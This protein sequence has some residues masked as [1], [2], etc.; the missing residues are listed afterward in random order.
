MIDRSSGLS[1]RNVSMRPGRSTQTQAERLLRGFA[2]C[3]DQA[4]SIHSHSDLP[5]FGN[6]YRG[7]RTVLN[8]RQTR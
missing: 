8:H 3:N 6:D 2:W 4:E 1:V 5:Q 7:F